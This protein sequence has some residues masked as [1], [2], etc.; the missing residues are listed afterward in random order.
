M[1]LIQFLK[2]TLLLI[3]AMIPFFG[4]EGRL[5]YIPD[6]RDIVFL[7]SHGKDPQGVLILF[8][9]VYAAIIGIGLWHLRRWARNSLVFSSGLMLVFWLAHHDFDTN[10]LIMPAVSEVAQQTVYIL[11]ALDFAIFVYLKFHTEIANAFPTT[12]RT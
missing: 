9:G 2:A 11:L 12:K 6:L 8:L 4:G 3:I 1:A 5:A 7:A 10:L